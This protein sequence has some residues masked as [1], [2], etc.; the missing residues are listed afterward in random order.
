MKDKLLVNDYEFDDFGRRAMADG[1][2][3]MKVGVYSIYKPVGSLIADGS[4]NRRKRGF[5]SDIKK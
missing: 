5:R 4:K 2:E 3:R 1:L